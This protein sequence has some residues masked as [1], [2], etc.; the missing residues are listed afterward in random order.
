M[1]IRMSN[2]LSK[3]LICGLGSIGRRYLRIIKRFFPD[4]KIAVL[5]SGHGPSCEE[6]KLIDYQTSN[7]N[8]TI[9]W[10]PE[11]SMIFNFNRNIDQKL[12]NFI[13][14]IRRQ[15]IFY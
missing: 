1:E 4:I 5:R 10:L 8:E 7:L 2:S 6:I 9:D 15:Q 13:E 14:K 11:A 3:I 12:R